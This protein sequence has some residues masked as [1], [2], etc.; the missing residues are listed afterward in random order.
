MEVTRSCRLRDTGRASQAL[1]FDKEEGQGRAKSRRS[2]A[3]TG[4]QMVP[5]NRE[6]MVPWRPYETEDPTI[7]WSLDEPEPSPA[8]MPTYTGISRGG[9]DAAVAKGGLMCASTTEADMSTYT[10]TSV[11]DL[12]LK[13]YGLLQDLVQ[14]L[15]YVL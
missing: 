15:P 3:R 4:V 14:F 7:S 10:V 1:Q 12:M 9:S 13:L 8:D 2:F 11:V 6:Q 5:R